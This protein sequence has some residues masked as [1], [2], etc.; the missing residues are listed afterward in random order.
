MTSAFEIRREGEV[1]YSKP[2]ARA[3]LRDGRL[4]FGARGLFAFLWDL[5]SG[6]KT[7][8]IHLA[9][10]SPQGR[11]AVRTLLKELEAV[12]AMRDEAIRGKGGRLAGSRWVLVTP[13]RW[14]IESPLSIH[15]TPETAPGAGS[16]ERRVFRSSGNPKVGKPSTKVYQGEGDSKKTTTTVPPEP[17]AHAGSGS[18]LVFDGLKIEP[19]IAPFFHQLMDVLRHAGIADAAIAQD[20]L[21]ELAGTIEAGIRGDRQ[22]IG[23]PVAWLQAVSTDF[24]R[25]R[26]VEVQ[27][28]RRSAKAREQ[29]KITDSEFVPDLLAQAKGEEFIANLKRR[30]S[31]QSEP[32]Q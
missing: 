28:K 23:N 26:C 11:D 8:S 13:E 2:L 4:S 31:Q 7:N 16:T 10:M 27:A 18:D 17:E 32:S 1:D 5:P 30:H 14:A 29:R 25:A 15:K 6:W 20:L 24:K 21:D 19:V 9:G 3:L 12:G 22:K